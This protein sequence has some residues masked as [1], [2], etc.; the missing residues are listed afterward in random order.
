[1]LPVVVALGVAGAIR[2][3][4]PRV[5]WWV[6]PAVAGAVW[7]PLPTLALGVAALAVTRRGVIHR[8]RAERTRA[9]RDAVA[10]AELVGLGLSAGLSFTAALEAA[11]R[12][13]GPPLVDELHEVIR[14]SRHRGIAVALEESGGAARRLY[15]LAAR[16]TVTGAPVAAAVRAYVAEQHD[17]DRARALAAARRLS[18]QLLFPLALLILPGFMV[19]TIGPALLG[20]LERLGM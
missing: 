13:V 9:E 10:L 11:A 17:A 1:M 7:Y 14:R 18:V 20:A 8:I 19:L 5:G 2:W 4:F 16:A 3:R 6:L 15:L 12:E